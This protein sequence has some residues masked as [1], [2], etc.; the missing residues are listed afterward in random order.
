[1][2]DYLVARQKGISLQIMRNPLRDVNAFL[3]VRKRIS[4]SMNSEFNE[5]NGF[6]PFLE[7]DLK[8]DMMSGDIFCNFFFC[9]FFF[10]F[11]FLLAFFEK[12]F[13]VAPICISGI[14][15]GGT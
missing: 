1:M 4:S 8:N 7:S 9:D 10:G 11:F 14:D 15:A 13:F 2:L 3:N 5:L 12:G 6:Q